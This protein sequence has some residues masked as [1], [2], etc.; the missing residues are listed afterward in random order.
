MVKQDLRELGF[1]DGLAGTGAQDSAAEAVTRRQSEGFVAGMG[2]K[3]RRAQPG[4]E[5]PA[6]KRGH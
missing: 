3:D 2:Q 4:Q 6:F 1:V 5:L